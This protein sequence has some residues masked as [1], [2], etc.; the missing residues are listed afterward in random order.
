VTEDLT[1]PELA[2]L[3]ARERGYYTPGTLAMLLDVPSWQ[4]AAARRRT[5]VVPEPDRSTTLA[6]SGQVLERWSIELA[7]G[8]AGILAKVVPE[9]AGGDRPMTAYWASRRLY[10]RLG[11]DA[12]TEDVEELV[13]RGAL[14]PIPPRREGA[15]PAF[16]APDVDALEA[17]L[18]AEVVAERPH[19]RAA[20][21]LL[22]PGQCR[23][24][25]GIRKSDW[26]HVVRRGWIEPA[27]H[28]EVSG[29]GMA[30]GRTIR[31][32]MYRLSDVD[33][34]LRREDVDWD[35]VRA[36]PKGE[37]SLLLGDD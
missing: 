20:R 6:R 29:R 2:R 10:E 7:E 19:R 26:D 24:R 22:H 34:L 15:R 18:V 9:A 21:T 36:T 35:E 3:H 25:L 14:A 8:H 13:R 1:D 23:R 5:G 32:P 11:V 31:V 30:R 27:E 17:T 4:L 28:Q 33:A 37:R 12:W 16:A